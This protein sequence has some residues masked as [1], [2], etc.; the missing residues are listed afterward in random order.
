MKYFR[1]HY[2]LG[3]Y[4]KIDFQAYKASCLQLAGIL[5]EFQ[6]VHGL[7]MKKSGISSITAE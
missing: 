1:A 7:N 6:V 4:F 5:T 2:W 3:F